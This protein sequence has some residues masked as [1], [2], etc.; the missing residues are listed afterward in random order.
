MVGPSRD[1]KTPTLCDA[2]TLVSKLMT[3]IVTGNTYTLSTRFCRSLDRIW[4][5][6]GS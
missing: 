6:N 3:F 2:C 5:T 1:S 4:Y